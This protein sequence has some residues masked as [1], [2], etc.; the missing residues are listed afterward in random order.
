MGVLRRLMIGAVLGMAV[1]VTIALS[2]QNIP[3][4][5]LFGFALTPTIFGF[6]LGSVVGLLIG[7][8]AGFVPRASK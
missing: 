6:M 2:H 5:A 1:G 4:L 8:A 7:L 3:S